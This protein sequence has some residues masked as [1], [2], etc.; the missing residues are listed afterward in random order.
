MK[1]DIGSVAAMAKKYHDG[2]SATLKLTRDLA[3]ECASVTDA[4]RCELGVK[5]FEC[6]HNFAKSRG[7][8]FEDV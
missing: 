5:I 1:L 4:D 3:T 2:D 7:I 6:G 8:S